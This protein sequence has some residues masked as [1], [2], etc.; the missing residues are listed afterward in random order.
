MRGAL[1]LCLSLPLSPELSSAQFIVQPPAPS[2]PPPPR[3]LFMQVTGVLPVPKS[4]CW[5]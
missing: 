3:K 2:S 1:R 5:V 4:P